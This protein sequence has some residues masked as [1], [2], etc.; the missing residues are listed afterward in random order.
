MTSSLGDHFDEPSPPAAPAEAEDIWH[1]AWRF[2]RPG[3]FR[4]LVGQHWELYLILAVYLGVGFIIDACYSEIA[5]V[6]LG[7]YNE[8]LRISVVAFLSFGGC[9]VAVM[10]MLRADRKRSL[11]RQVFGRLA[12]FVAFERLAPFAAVILFIHVFA[13]LFTSLKTMIPHLHPFAWD[14]TFMQWDQSVHFGRHPWEWLQPL[15][16]PLFTFA[17]NFAYNLWMFV[18]FAVLLWQAWSTNRQLRK[19]YLICFELCWILIGT[20]GAT[21]LSSAGP[22]YYAR[23][24]GETNDPYAAQMKY[25][26]DVHEHHF[27]VFALDVQEK[28][29]EGY[30]ADFLGIQPAELE[31]GKHPGDRLFVGIS[32]MPSLHVS[33][34]VLMALVGWSTNCWLGIV[35]SIF[36]LSIQLGS[37][38]LGWHYAIDGYLSAVLTVILW[39]AVGRLLR[40]SRGRDETPPVANSTAAARAVR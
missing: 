16:S 4:F 6:K 35:L 18:M 30:A 2:Y 32:A 5:V 10:T 27:P 37:V 19:Q 8:V 28:L 11:L 15:A 13:S 14:H 17:I 12:E 7:L 34:A 23:V 20:V 24:T 25:L 31:V 36:A 9:G 33:I 3:Q 22:C 26:Y 1:D 40:W 39:F 29:W 38:Y 21:V